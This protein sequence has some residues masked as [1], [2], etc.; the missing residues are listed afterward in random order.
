MLQLFTTVQTGNTLL[1]KM[2]DAGVNPVGGASWS[3]APCSA[4][5]GALFW[6]K[7]SFRPILHEEML[8]EEMSHE[9][10]EEALIS[11]RIDCTRGRT[12]RL[13]S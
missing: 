8:R 6:M 4:Y 7:C 10:I 3:T 11:D 12:N 1:D 13:Y 5:H 9:E 2:E